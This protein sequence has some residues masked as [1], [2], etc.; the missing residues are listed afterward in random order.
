MNLALVSAL[1][2]VVAHAAAAVTGRRTLSLLAVAVTLIALALRLPA[3]GAAAVGLAIALGLSVNVLSGGTSKL[4]WLALTS[5]LPGALF[6][7]AALPAGWLAWVGA[8][9]GAAMIAVATLAAS[10]AALR[11]DR[12]LRTILALVV[13]AAPMPLLAASPMAAAAELPMALNP[14]ATI[15]R[16]VVHLP[17]AELGAWAVSLWQSLA[18]IGALAVAVSWASGKRVV[19]LALGGWAACIAIAAVGSWTAISA[20]LDGS[21]SAVSADPRLFPIS[22]A[23]GDAPRQIDGAA[24]LF[25]ASRWTL[26]AALLLMPAGVAQVAGRGA[27]FDGLLASLGVASICLWGVV[28]P[29]FVGPYWLFDPAALAVLATIASSIALLHYHTGRVAALLRG[30]QFAA[31]GLILGGGDLGW[32]VASALVTG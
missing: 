30:V 5:A 23:V 9:V 7:A 18:W 21:L 25:A 19:W 2:A 29:G 17:T 27:A 15:H 22:V 16:G 32:R 3:V 6:A 24:G 4:H 8:G 31:C 13:A 10:R 14:V 20:W 1:A 12:E 28:A 11:G 26:A